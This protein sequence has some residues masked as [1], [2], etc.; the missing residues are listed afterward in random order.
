MPCACAIAAMLPRDLQL[1]VVTNAPDIA[2]LL[3]AREG[4]EVSL[5]GG[6]LDRRSGAVLGSQ[7][8]ECLAELRALLP[9][10][11]QSAHPRRPSACPLR[12]I[13]R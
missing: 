11:S 6:R 10:A 8:M 12:H 1:R 13:R 9:A 7:A 4:I 3:M 5:I 2:L